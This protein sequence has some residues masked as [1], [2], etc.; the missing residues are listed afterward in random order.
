M[1]PLAGI[2]ILD[3]MR[4]VRCPVLVGR[5]PEVEALTAAVRRAVEGDGGLVFVVGEAGVGK[6][7]LAAVAAAEA[8]AK[9][10]AVLRGRAAPSP[11]P[12][13][14]RPLAEA[15]LSVLRASGPPPGLSP[16]LSVLIPAWAH[17]GEDRPAEPSL[18]LLGEAVLDLLRVV[19]GPK[20]ATV[21][22]EDLHWADMGT[23]E[24]LDYVADKLEGS[25]VVVVVTVR[26]GEGSEAERQAA[27]LRS[28]R[29]AS[30][31]DLSRLVPGGVRT[32][33]SALLETD[34]V[35]A[36][37]IDVVL[38]ASEGLPFLVEEVVASL[39]DSGAVMRMETGS[40]EIQGRL[41]PAVPPSFAALV[42]ERL[43][44]LAEPAATDVVKAAAVL[45]E[46]FDW[47]MLRATCDCDDSSLLAALRQAASVQLVEEDRRA[48]AFRFR[49][50]LT[51]AAVLETL[52]LPERAA[53]A[54]R[55][56][57]AIE[58][59]PLTD[60]D[61]L[62]LAAELAETAGDRPRANELLV[63]SASAALRTGAVTPALA[64]AERVIADAV[65]AEQAIRGHEILLDGS[66]LAGNVPRVVEI[67]ERLLARLAA[68]GAPA[69]RRA[70]AHLRLAAAALAATDWRRV[71]DHLALVEE[72]VPE[73]D[74]V[75]T[76]RAGILRAQVDLG[77]HRVHEAARHARATRDVAARL[78]LADLLCESLEVLGRVDRVA[79]LA[80]AERHFTEAFVTAEAAGLALRRV[81]ALHELGTI[82]LVRLGGTD[83]LQAARDG[84]LAIGAPGLEAQA[85][86]HL[87]VALFVRY[88]LDEARAAVDRSLDI[89]RRHHL[90]LLVPAVLTVKGGI[91]AVSGNREAA[92][93]AFEEALPLSDAEIEATG[94]GHVLGLAALASED[95]GGALAQFDRAEAL[96]PAHS[97]VARAP[98]RGV[99]ALVESLDPERSTAVLDDLTSE[100][101]SVHVATIAL[102]DLA[103][104]V[105]AGR[106]GD[107]ASAE[108]FLDAGVSAL[109][110]AP[111]YRNLGR[112]LVAEAAI[113][114][115]WGAPAVWLREALEFFEDAGLAALARACRS[116]LRRAGAPVP[117]RPTDAY[118]APDLAHLGVTKRE[119][120]VLSL[121][122]EGL[123]NRD[124]ASRLYL[125]ARTVEKHVER[126]MLKTGTA[127][128][129]QLAALAART[130]T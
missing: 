106:A 103:R 50:A 82:D 115:S 37:V 15:F 121:V 88:R 45:G 7:R 128:R 113:E 73:A 24:L 116:L 6:S 32:M 111:F 91:E 41:E 104:A 129:A 25:A 79:D 61:R 44:S 95:R 69:E 112:R 89:A 78:G 62:E 23:L 86:M 38:E 80:K 71:R 12:V 30:V 8:R 54:A 49:H 22:L 58:A 47:S 130:N 52:L 66:V 93:A 127:N 74:E 77:E 117:R 98:Y 56:L 126:L 97:G 4:D 3:R 16:A 124:I 43:A 19:A 123:S 59:G 99:Y 92:A 17:P 35:P 9:G 20:G 96:V 64:T 55:A 60:R 109:R 53:L 72:L 46:Q 65:D 120:D 48:R 31:I 63:A 51:R 101:A 76:A 5:E 107:A 102:A 110:D 34:D 114:D 2:A 40:V 11:A 90:G 75:L 10:M 27:R 26:T 94:R 84:A 118:I 108:A 57:A 21:V 122:A 68:T 14:Y 1:R 67:G 105:R 85:G 18:I 36:G 87:G 100:A 70:E 125:S 83:R 119:V 39:L 33:V 42:A 13:P 81:R 29:Q 28:R